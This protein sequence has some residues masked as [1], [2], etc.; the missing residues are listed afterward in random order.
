[1]GACTAVIKVLDEGLTIFDDII[2]VAYDEAT[3]MEKFEIANGASDTD[4]F[5]SQI[6]TV[7]FLV[8][9]S[10]Q[11]ITIKQNSSSTDVTVDA[12]KPLLITGGNLTALTISNASGSTANIRRFAAGT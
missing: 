10:D 7:D 6:T 4:I 9:R 11:A 2:G 12:K 1:M 8:L 5:P 3:G